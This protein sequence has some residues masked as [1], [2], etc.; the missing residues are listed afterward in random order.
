MAKPTVSEEQIYTREWI[1]Q[2]T[3]H[4]NHHCNH[5][6][7][8]HSYEMADPVIQLAA[9]CFLETRHKNVFYKLLGMGYWQEVFLKLTC[10]H[11]TPSK[12][13]KSEFLWGKD[14]GERGGWW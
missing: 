14:I 3:M 6:L 2:G 9:A 1:P 4:W 12:T 5:L 13:N 7:L 8:T 10:Q 11:P